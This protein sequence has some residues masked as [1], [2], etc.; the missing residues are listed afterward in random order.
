M[1]AAIPWERKEICPKMILVPMLRIMARPMV[2]RKSTGSNQEVVVIA[3]TAKIT[4]TPAAM[5][6]GISRE[7]LSSRVLFSMAGPL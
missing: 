5:I 2:S 1:T 6:I 4:T 3:S 7:I